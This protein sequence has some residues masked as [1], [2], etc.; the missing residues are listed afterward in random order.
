VILGRVLCAHVADRF[1]LDAQRCHIDT[2][3]LRMIGRMHG[4][5]WYARTTDLFQ[6]ERARWA[7]LK[8]DG[9]G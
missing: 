2:P 7:D 3:A 5:G 4:A 1:V 9:I 8:K 6:I